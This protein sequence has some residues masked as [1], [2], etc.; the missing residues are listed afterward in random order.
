MSLSALVVRAADQVPSSVRSHQMTLKRAVAPPSPLYRTSM[1]VARARASPTG[2]A[3]S[4]VRL[5]ASSGPVMV[6][7]TPVVGAA[8]TDG[9]RTRQ[10][11]SHAKSTCTFLLSEKQYQG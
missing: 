2:S 5:F 7:A 4:T 8:R 1:L 11:S 3:F 10:I 9:K 6:V